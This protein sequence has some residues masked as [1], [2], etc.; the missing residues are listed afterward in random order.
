MKL[1]L[2]TIRGQGISLPSGDRNS[3]AAKEGWLICIDTK[4]AN[5]SQWYTYFSNG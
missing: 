2:S 3:A 4:V 1:R 5:G